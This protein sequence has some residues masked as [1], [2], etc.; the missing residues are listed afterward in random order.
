V[1]L[2]AWWGKDR[3]KRNAR[4]QQQERAIAKR[5]GGRI[6][7]G[8]GSSHRSPGD[9]RTPPGSLPALDPDAFLVEAKYA[10]EDKVGFTITRD[11]L[12]LH[13]SRARS[14][15]R[16]PAF[17]I[18]FLGEPAYKVWILFEGV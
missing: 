3:E 2:P 1:T 14:V 6:T 15:G 17:A 16:E 5:T 8:S 10:G 18:E 11:M 13:V 4:S 9:V 12:G 7:P